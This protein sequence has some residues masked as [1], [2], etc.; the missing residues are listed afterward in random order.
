MKAALQIYLARK[1]RRWLAAL[2]T[3]I[4]RD[5]FSKFQ[6]EPKNFVMDKPYRLIRPE[7]ISMGDDVY[8][9]PNS[10]LNC[11]AHY[12]SDVMHAP[13]GIEPKIYSPRIQIGDRVFHQ[14]FGMGDVRSVEGDKL[15]IAFDK[16]GRKKVVSSF[17]S[18]P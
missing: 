1:I 16:A 17:V 13:D 4:E 9:G 8:L 3:Q 12:P 15:D 5:S 7:F 2:E 18:K 6:S 10:M 14:K 11:M